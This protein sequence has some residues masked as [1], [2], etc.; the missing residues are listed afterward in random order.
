MSF[1]IIDKEHWKRKEY[2]EHFYSSSPCTYS[3]TVKIDITKIK[4]SKVRLYPAMLYCIT[5]VVNNHEE[6]RTAFDVNGQL[7]VFE[8]M[9]PYYTIFHDDTKTFS[10]IWT[11]YSDKYEVFCEAYERDIEMFGF[12]KDIDAK[13]DIPG[14]SFTVSMIPWGGFEGFNLNIQKGY[15]YL[16]LSSRWVNI[17]TKM[18]L[19]CYH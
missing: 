18:I 1:R 8:D 16:L 11:K 12:I 4:Q 5:K 19:T 6:F 10:N 2:F 13:P 3:M 17:I 9:L 14:N 15:N 7:G